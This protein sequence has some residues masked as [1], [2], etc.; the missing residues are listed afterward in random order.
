MS[1]TK[2]NLPDNFQCVLL[3]TFDPIGTA[4]YSTPLHKASLIFWNA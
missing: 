2:L 1:E 4:T 3:I